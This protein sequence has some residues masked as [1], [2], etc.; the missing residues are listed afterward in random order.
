MIPFYETFCMGV[1]VPYGVFLVGRVVALS[2]FAI[3]SFNIEKNYFMTFIFL[4]S[5]LLAY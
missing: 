1:Y 4:E 5:M 2:K 3:L